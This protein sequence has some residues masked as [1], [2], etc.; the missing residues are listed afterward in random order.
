MVSIVVTVVGTMMLSFIGGALGLYL[1]Y[2]ALREAQ[3]S[4]QSEQLARIAVG[5]G[6]ISV[7][8]SVLPMCLGFGVWG[9]GICSSTGGAIF[10]GL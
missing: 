7:I 10:D 5:I 3:E 1:A 6:W 8:L 4:G 2:K 9:M